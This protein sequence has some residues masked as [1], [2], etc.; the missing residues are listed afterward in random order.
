M[1]P[2]NFFCKSNWQ[3][4]YY[5]DIII[6][7]IFIKIFFFLRRLAGGTMARKNR[8]AAK[9]LDRQVEDDTGSMMNKALQE[10]G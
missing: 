1:F 2:H 8:C 4:I 10:F 9:A 7:F 5:I 3:F 6:N